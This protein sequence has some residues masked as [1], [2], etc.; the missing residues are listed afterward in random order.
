MS[1]ESSKE[2]NHRTTI[3]VDK[4]HA[5]IPATRLHQLHKLPGHLPREIKQNINNKLLVSTVALS[6]HLTR[7]GNI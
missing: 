2:D 4:Q 7:N 5:L 3:Q 6:H 1:D